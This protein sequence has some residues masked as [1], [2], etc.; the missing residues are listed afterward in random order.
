MLENYYISSKIIPV[1]TSVNGSRFLFC[2]N[3]D[4]IL[5]LHSSKLY[6]IFRD[7][8][9]FI[10]S[11]NANSVWLS[12]AG[13]ELA[14]LISGK[15]YRTCKFSLQPIYTSPISPYTFTASQLSYGDFIDE[16]RKLVF[17]KYSGGR[18]VEVYDL[19]TGD[20][21]RTETIST[22]TSIMNY[23][24]YGEGRFIAI[25]SNGHVVIYDYVGWRVVQFSHMGITNRAATYDCNSNVIL[26]VDID[27]KIRVFGLEDSGNGLSSPA[28]SPTG[29]KYLYSGYVLSTR[30]TGAGGNPIPN[31]WVNW[32]LVGIKGTLEKPYSLTDA[33][34]YAWNYYWCPTDISQLGSETVRVW[35]EQ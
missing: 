21:I 23:Y 2:R 34:G 6:K 19:I 11:P 13:G 10:V 16:E 17:H 33:N 9:S 27:G 4:A 14:A 18:I 3:W 31:A 7:G 8:T 26:M 12:M 30:L 15:L 25:G 22:A 35:Y 28:F 5:S 20:L 24:Y 32:E 1:Y 29:N